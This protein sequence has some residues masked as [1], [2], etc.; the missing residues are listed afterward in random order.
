M[1]NTA[2][3]S[4]KYKHPPT[5]WILALANAWD[6]FSYFGTQTILVLYLMH[7]FDLSRTDSYISY[8]AYAAFAYG[9]PLFGGMVGDRLSNSR[10]AVAFGLA[11]NIIGNLTMMLLS[12]PSFCIG[13]G[14]S[15]IGTGLS[16]S[17][18]M[19]LAG[20]LY[21]DNTLVKEAGFTLIY[22][23][24][25]I[26]GALAPITYGIIAYKVG[27]NYIF[28]L[29]AIGITLSLLIYLS[30]WNK[31]KV[32]NTNISSTLKN[33]AIFTASII[34]ALLVGTILYYT[35]VSFWLLIMFFAAAL[36]YLIIVIANQKTKNKTHL[37]ALFVLCSFALFY[38][39]AGLQIGS[40]ITLF[41]QHKIQQ[42]IIK[43][44][45]PASIFSVLYCGFVLLLAPFFSTLWK[46][47]ESVKRPLNPVYK[48]NLGILLAGLGIAAFTISAITN[49]VII[50]TIIGV[51]LLSAGELV[52][53]PTI[54]TIINNK[55]PKN[56]R[57]TFMGG[58]Y[59]FMAL[60]GYLSSVLASSAHW[61]A[62]TASVFNNYFASEFF[63]ISSFTLTIAIIMLFTAQKIIRML[64]T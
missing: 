36:G 58:W 20:S 53:M 6:T 30:Q 64:N 29:N 26:G 17:N 5:L 9:L 49:L 35:K 57:S 23:A 22:I 63:Y 32:N 8:G 46:K 43:I 62:E 27:W 61:L 25:N 38:F 4:S 50:G 24:I 45:L 54:L 16:K 10:N 3:T 19:Q 33:T 18:S 15:L 52:L 7:V 41:L 11:L 14:F 42:G 40:T 1:T 2:M 31:W 37:F 48:V 60:G 34:S 47:L 44:K 21:K 28:S 39:T 55:S 13:M 51:M 56:L 12:L 59:L